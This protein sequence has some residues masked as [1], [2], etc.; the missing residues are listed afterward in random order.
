MTERLALLILVLWPTTGPA[1]NMTSIFKKASILLIA[2]GAFPFL[3]SAAT[4]HLNKVTEESSGSKLIIEILLDSDEILNAIEGQLNFPKEL[5]EVFQISDGDSLIT[6]WVEKPNIKT[7]GL[8]SFSGITPGGFYGEN[9]KVFSVVFLGKGEGEAE[10][11]LMNIKALLND[12]L[13][14]ETLIE[15]KTLKVPVSRNT[16]APTYETST[17]KTPP[18]IFK[19]SIE[20]DP[21]IFE[22]QHFLVFHTQDKDTGIDY[23]EVREGD[24]GEF[25][26]ASSPYLLEHQG[27]DK[28]L[29]VKAV[30]RAGNQITVEL[31]SKN[32]KKEW[33]ESSPFVIII[34]IVIIVLG[35]FLTAWLKLKK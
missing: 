11:N 10:F 15:T 20:S 22:G 8:I 33:E 1:K 28:K 13:G 18:E 2:L 25:K 26:K 29:F 35:L 24:S 21:N 16:D 34:L 14:T 19:P 5:L 23:Y 7:P 12:G 31:E 32:L 27:L 6:F 3:A 4:L 17:D 9:R 30:D